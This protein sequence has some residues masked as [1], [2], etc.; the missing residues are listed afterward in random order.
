MVYFRLSMLGMF[1]YN[2]K[3]RSWWF[4]SA[5]TDTEQEFNLLGVVSFKHCFAKLGDL[6]ND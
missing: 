6:R 5:S 4:N 1:T 3:V 2:S